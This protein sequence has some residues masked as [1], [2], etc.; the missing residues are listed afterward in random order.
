[1]KY[2]NDKD[3][4]ILFHASKNNNSI[5]AHEEEIKKDNFFIELTRI[6]L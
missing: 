2:I 5:G 1:M 6:A 3:K 4:N